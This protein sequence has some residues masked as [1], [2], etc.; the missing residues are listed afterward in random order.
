MDRHDDPTING[1]MVLLR[2]IPPYG[3]RVQWDDR[4]GEPTPSSQNFKDRNNELS[5]FLAAEITA[6]AA[7]AGHDGFGL[8]Q[9]TAGRVREALGSGII[10]C[11]DTSDP[12]P[13][14][15]IICGKVTDGMA[16]R[17]RSIASWVPGRWPARL[18]PEA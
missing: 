7:L 16:R 4:T 15:V 1:D 17:F 5:T 8:V 9:F 6:D 10:F 3:D 18:R 2:R 13:G 12:T 14:H 11:R